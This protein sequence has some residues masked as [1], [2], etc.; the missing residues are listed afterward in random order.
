[1]LTLLPPL[2]KTKPAIWSDC[3]ADIVADM[4]YDMLCC[5]TDIHTCISLKRTFAADCCS[6]KHYNECCFQEIN[7]FIM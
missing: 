2:A 3:D 5:R 1:M 7:R 4:L 6:R